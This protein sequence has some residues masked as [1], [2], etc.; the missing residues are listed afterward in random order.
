MQ[1]YNYFQNTSLGLKYF[2]LH[3]VPRIVVHQYITLP[4]GIYVKINLSGCILSVS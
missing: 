1:S 2:I 4:K 3:P